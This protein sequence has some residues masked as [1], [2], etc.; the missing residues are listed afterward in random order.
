M[1]VFLSHS[2]LV[3]AE[4]GA[5]GAPLKL[6][7]APAEGVLSAFAYEEKSALEAVLS[8]PPGASIENVRGDAFVE[9][10]PRDESCGILLE[11]DGE[12]PM[13]IPGK[14]VRLMQLL[15]EHHRSQNGGAVPGEPPRPPAPGL[16][17]PVVQ[18]LKECLVRNM[19]AAAAFLPSAEGGDRPAFDPADA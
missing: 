8:L 10:L 14:L 3:L 13:P 2:F 12:P 19:E 4:K 5:R 9:A 6:R 11:I 17:P 16:P 7:L 15:V 1:A 18:A